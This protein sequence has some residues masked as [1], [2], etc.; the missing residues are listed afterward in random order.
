MLKDRFKANYVS[1]NIIANGFCLIKQT[2]KVL[3]V[4]KEVVE[5]RLNPSLTMY[6]IMLKGYF[7]AS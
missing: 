7:K 6:N 4:L 2:P 3:E 5:R 1:Y